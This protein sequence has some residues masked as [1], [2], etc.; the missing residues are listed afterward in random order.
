MHVLYLCTQRCCGSA[1]RLW[2]FLQDRTYTPADPPGPGR[3]PASNS[4]THYIQE[5]SRFPLD[6]GLKEHSQLEA[7]KSNTAMCFHTV[8][9]GTLRLGGCTFLYSPHILPLRTEP[10]LQKRDALL[11]SSDLGSAIIISEDKWKLDSGCLDSVLFS[12]L[13]SCSSI[14]RSLFWLATSIESFLDRGK[15]MLAGRMAKV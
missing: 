12:L 7:R 9:K 13:V 11:L 2:R 8:M 14:R 4:H 3:N 5:K 15:G 6:I 1:G 10:G